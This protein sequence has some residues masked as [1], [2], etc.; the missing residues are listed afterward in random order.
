MSNLPTVSICIVNYNGKKY[1]KEC[2]ESLKELDYPKN[3]Y[4]VIMADNAS[5][6]GSVEYVKKEFPWVKI[7]ELDKNY[8]FCKANNLCAKEAKGEYLVFLNND[9]VVTKSWLKYLVEGV[10]SEKDVISA[11][12]KMLKPYKINDKN[13][14]DYAGGKISPDGGGIY[15][16]MLDTYQEKYN[17]KKYTGFG[18][19]AGVIV[20]KDFFLYTGGFDEYFFAGFEE[21][22]LGLRVW[23]YGYRVIYAPKSVMYHKRLG[24]FRNSLNLDML[25]RN[26]KNRFYFILKNFEIKT[27]FIFLFFALLKSVF[28]ILYFFQKGNTNASMAI[29]RGILL[30]LKDVKNEKLIKRIIRKRREIYKNKKVSDKELFTFGVISTIKEKIYYGKKYLKAADMD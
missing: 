1:L 12:C 9:T 23:R 27:C 7:L 5:S 16:G 11:G 25:A 2:L 28:E 17:V 4:E 3:K 15:E 24:T 21:I 6:D 10:L 26:S 20:K 13:V 29:V 14:I 22:D 19:G 30:F 18:C 8:G